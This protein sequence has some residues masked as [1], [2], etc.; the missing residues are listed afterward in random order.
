MPDSDSITIPY[1]PKTRA[2][3]NLTGKTFHRLTV[4]GFSGYRSA[5]NGSYENPH[6]LCRCEC[7]GKLLIVK[8]HYLTRNSATSCGCWKSEQSR[9]NATTHGLSVKR[10]EQREYWIW[11]SMKQRCLNPKDRAYRLYGAAGRRICEGLLIFENFI[12]ILG[13]RPNPH[14]MLDREDNNGDYSCGKCEQCLRENW[15]LNI[16]WVNRTVSNNN[17]SRNKLVTHLGITRTLAEWSAV[18]GLAYKTVHARFQR[19]YSTEDALFIGSYNKHSKR[20]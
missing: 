1:V 13:N 8:G 20:L 12:A 2:S 5:G 17:T 14:Y 4:V 18:L 10:I 11:I 3:Q 6:W 7:D 15:P 19:G 16:R 9:I